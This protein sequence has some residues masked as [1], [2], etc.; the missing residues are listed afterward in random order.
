[1]LYRYLIHTI[2]RPFKII[3]TDHGPANKERKKIKKGSWPGEREGGKIRIFD[4]KINVS[5]PIRPNPFAT[6]R[7]SPFLPIFIAA[8]ENDVEFFTPERLLVV[9]RRIG[10]KN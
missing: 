7:M 2:W 6:Q 8:V 3:K 1:V 10:K 5:I 9:D 4:Y